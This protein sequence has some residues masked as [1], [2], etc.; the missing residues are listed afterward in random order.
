MWGKIFVGR[1]VQKVS[2]ES[3][4]L[5][6]VLKTFFICFNETTK[7]Y[8]WNLWKS[9]LHGSSS[10]VQNRKFG[11]YTPYRQIPTDKVLSL[12]QEI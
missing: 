11:S 6:K 2:T 9:F 8:F 1:S 3:E 5:K 4:N 12:K 10:V 7:H